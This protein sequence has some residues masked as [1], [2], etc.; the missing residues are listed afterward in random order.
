MNPGPATA[1]DPVVSRI[2]TAIRREA[3][4]KRNLE[5]TTGNPV[6]WPWPV[7][8]DCRQRG[9]RVHMTGSGAISQFTYRVSNRRVLNFL[10][11]A[12]LVVVCMT[13]RA[14]RLIRW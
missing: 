14:I 1:A 3:L 13:A 6:L 11:R 4:C 12:G 9:V 8:L 2:A 10:M 5:S 7:L